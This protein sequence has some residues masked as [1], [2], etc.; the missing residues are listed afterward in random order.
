MSLSP[1][2]S[3]IPPQAKPAIHIPQDVP[4]FMITDEKGFYCDDH[5]HE[6]GAIIAWEEEPN[7]KMHHMNDLA[8]EAYMKYLDKLDGFGRERATRDKTAYTSQLDAFLRSL[9]PEEGEDNRRAKVLG[10]K[11]NVPVMGAKRGAI[12]AK[13]LDANADAPN[14]P[15]ADGAAIFNGTK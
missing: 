2:L 7:P 12:K 11:S 8:Q 1:R 10:P 5:L 4:V 13:R 3:P 6:N 14:I 15:G 9:E